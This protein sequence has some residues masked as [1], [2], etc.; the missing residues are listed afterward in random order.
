MD[1]VARQQTLY[2][3]F[4]SLLGYPDAQTRPTA[5]ACMSLLGETHSQAVPAM[6]GFSDFIAREEPAR[7]EE[8]YTA[9]FD[10]QPAC[11]PYVGYQ[12]CGESQKRAFFLMQ[13]QQLYRQHDF[14]VGGELPDHLGTMLR[15]LGSTSDAVCRQE[16]VADGLLPALDKLL[17]GLDPVAQP[18]G[19]LLQALH[20]FLTETIAAGTESPPVAEP[21]ENCS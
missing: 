1:T 2:R 14:A 6:A 19:Q 8:I 12:L 18:Y 16:L 13:L 4:S 11:Y 5:R 17:P 20:S 21:K 10:L 15:F 7:V 3:Q 9:T